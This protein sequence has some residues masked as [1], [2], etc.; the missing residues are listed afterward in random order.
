ML[1]YFKVDDVI[2]ASPVHFFCGMWGVL[3]TGLFAAKDLNGTHEYGLLHGGGGH[4]L[5]WQLIGIICIT[6]W[7][8]GITALLLFGFQFFDCLRISE[9][10][11]QIGLDALVA[12]HGQLAIN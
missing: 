3:A 8:G 4:L 11:E 12:K 9:E 6:A 2:D 1:K 7:T 10:E 5:G